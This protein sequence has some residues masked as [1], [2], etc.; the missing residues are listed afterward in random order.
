ME[1]VK[2]KN[3]IKTAETIRVGLYIDTVKTEEIRIKSENVG[4]IGKRL[5]Q[6]QEASQK[7]QKV[8]DENFGIM[9]PEQEENFP[10]E[11]MQEDE[12]LFKDKE[13]LK[14]NG[15]ALSQ[16]STSANSNQQIS[17]V[18][19]QGLPY[20]PTD[21]EKAQY[22]LDAERRKIDFAA[23]NEVHSIFA[24]TL[25]K[26]RQENKAT[27]RNRAKFEE[28]IVQNLNSLGK[29]HGFKDLIFHN[30]FSTPRVDK[31]GYDVY[32][33]LAQCKYCNKYKLHFT[34]QKDMNGQPVMITYERAL[35]GNRH[36]M[37]KRH[38]RLSD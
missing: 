1:N 4:Q 7:R 17:P 3:F 21:E 31:N 19:Q 10:N 36:D 9:S 28:K 2:F 6:S 27:V 29:E 11:Q 35:H 20:L 34:Y 25:H 18:L 12:Q 33:V 15:L 14:L 5:K 38:P 22:K 23:L 16:T 32:F 26:L 30:S 13:A 8:V 37:Q 24:Y